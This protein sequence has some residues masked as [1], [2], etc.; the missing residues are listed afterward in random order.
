MAK[1][2]SESQDQSKINKIQQKL[3]KLSPFGKRG[4]KKINDDNIDGKPKDTDVFEVEDD[5]GDVNVNNSR[6]EDQSV[7]MGRTRR[8]ILTDEVEP[9]YSQPTKVKK[10]SKKKPSNV[11]RSD[12]RKKKSKL[13]ESEQFNCNYCNKDN[14]KHMIECE[15]CEKWSC[16]DCQNMPP[17][18]YEI[19]AVEKNRMHW[20][21]NRCEPIAVNAAKQSVKPSSGVESEYEQ[22]DLDVMTQ[23][24]QSQITNKVTEK[25]NEVLQEVQK[26]VKA[27][28]DSGEERIERAYRNYAEV[29]RNQPVH[30]ESTTTTSAS[31]H[32]TG[33]GLVD[34]HDKYKSKS[35]DT[36]N[37]TEAGIAAIEEMTERERR[38]NNL[39]IFN[40]PE[41]TARSPK[42][43]Q[44]YDKSVVEELIK[45]GIEVEGVEVIK[46]VRLG[47]IGQNRLAKPRVTLIEVQDHSTKIRI[48]QSAR[49]LRSKD[50]WATTFV[51][52]DM[53]PNQRKQRKELR[54]ELNQRRARGEENI[55]IRRG[56]IVAMKDRQRSK[57][58]I[59]DIS[60]SDL[61]KGQRP[62]KAR[63]T[64]KHDQENL[65]NSHPVHPNSDE[66]HVPGAT[67]VHY[68]DQAT[69]GQR[70]LEE[71]GAV[72]GVPENQKQ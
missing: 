8:V 40:L 35:N 29:V 4:E 52:P 11:S 23:R 66:P 46:V 62:T 18:V 51:A 58:S 69:Q 2:K 45:T 38:K 9:T 43:R 65:E 20:Y 41:S 24:V 5:R 67:Q 10:Q 71:L 12:L 48:L 55:I 36:F 15:A 60:L 64:T 19:F 42:G 49:N 32:A 70:G 31:N 54:T 7:D 27:M 37:N 44:E 53:T 1:D 25:M 57:T 68:S 21:C 13:G 6:A 39:V 56:V 28:L 3:N 33:G 17:D 14:A 72:G 26:T 61:L 22:L 30:V 34:R 50:M 16:L 63:T 47:G 59:N